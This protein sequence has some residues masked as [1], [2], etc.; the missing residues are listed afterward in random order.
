[1]QH[2]EEACTKAQHVIGVTAVGAGQAAFFGR[3]FVELAVGQQLDDVITVSSNILAALDVHAVFL[4][5]EHQEHVV[6]LLQYGLVDLST[7]VGEGAVA[8][9]GVIAGCAVGVGHDHRVAVRV[10]IQHLGGP[11]EFFLRHVVA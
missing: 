7:V 9:I 3:D 5:G 11:I 6:V 1:M 10:L 8:A 2:A 4:A